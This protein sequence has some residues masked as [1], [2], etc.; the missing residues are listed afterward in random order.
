MYQR[1]FIVYLYYK[2]R[3]QLKTFLTQIGPALPLTPDPP[4]R[5]HDDQKA[6]MAVNRNLGS[7]SAKNLILF[8]HTPHL[9]IP[10]P[11][12]PPLAR[13]LPRFVSGHRPLLLLE[14]PAARS[15]PQPPPPPNAVGIC[16]HSPA[17][18]LPLGADAR[19]R[20]RS[21]NLVPNA[22]V[23]QGVLKITIRHCF[24][25]EGGGGGYEIV[26]NFILHTLPLQ[27]LVISCYLIILYVFGFRSSYPL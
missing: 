11:P 17:S 2:E 20:K 21:T 3:R 18:N 23:L 9:P 25:I 10:Y 6:E 14:S 7:V 5:L 15:D 27:V 16:H 26:R 12:G 13:N 24:S 19:R 8:S 22:R 4:I 1:D